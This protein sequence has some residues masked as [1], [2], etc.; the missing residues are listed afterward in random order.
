MFFPTFV[1]K[2]QT[3]PFPCITGKGKGIG[4][5]LLPSGRLG[6]GLLLL[7]LLLLTACHT[8]TPN[9]PLA[10]TSAATHYAALLQMQDLADG[11]TLVRIL[12][13]WQTDRTAMQYLL[14]P[15][16]AAETLA[17]EKVD[18]IEEQFG[19][20]QT[21]TTPVPR[22]T[23]TASCYA[24]LFVQLDA[25]QFIGVMCDAEYIHNEQIVKAL[26]DGSIADGGS[27]MN[28]NAE[29]IT[30]AHSEAI[31]LTPY[32]AGSQAVISAVLPQLPVIY[33][34]DYQENTPLGRAE[35]MRFFGRLVNRG[36]EADSLFA[37]V[38]THMAALA[39]TT[40]IS[41]GEAG[42]SAIKNDRPMLLCDLPYG[43]TWY[44]PGGRS[45]MSWLYQD[46][47]F[48]Y[49]WSDDTHGGSLALSMEAVFDRARTADCWI[50]KYFDPDG[51]WTSATLRDQNRLFEHIKAM[52]DGNIF[53]CNTANSDYFEVTPFRP[54]MMLAE[55]R[56]IRRG[57]DDS[58]RFF[59]RLK[60]IE[61]E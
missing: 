21:L 43:A 11:M 29:V 45:T 27:S 54:D 36:R 52:A 19:R 31:W 37:V 47:G 53:G 24:D 33:C 1:H 44:V 46:A 17:D 7:T 39:D 57:E 23:L 58:L 4:S 8:R 14:V 34:A 16:G 40:R 22:Q 6:G 18:E 15:E 20:V 9:E 51:D 5:A 13:P 26:A 61:K 35:W 48:R 50:F 60:N 42:A 56:H 55:M 32:E 28:P 25:T 30:A 49:P 10:E 3:T 38:A 41:E 59:R 2:K 12:N